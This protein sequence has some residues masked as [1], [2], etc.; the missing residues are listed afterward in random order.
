MGSLA[1]LVSLM[2]FVYFIATGYNIQRTQ[3][4]VSLDR[5]DGE[6]NDVPLTVDGSY[7]ATEK[8]IWEGAESFQ[9]N[10]AVYYL[11]LTNYKSTKAEYAR[12]MNSIVL[13]Q[14]KAMAAG[15]SRRNAAG[16]V[17][18]WMT[19]TAALRPEVEGDL[20]YFAMAGMLPALS[21]IKFQWLYV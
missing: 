9:Y 12:Q 11:Q 8:G 3:A 17:L 16:N 20:N 13:P 21:K 6:C 4:F 19:W 1:Y 15:A 5:H 10:D 18:L 14:L 2:T 7:L